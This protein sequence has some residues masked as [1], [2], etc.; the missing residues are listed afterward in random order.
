[1]IAAGIIYGTAFGLPLCDGDLAECTW[2]ARLSGAS[3][4]EALPAA[5]MVL[6]GFSLH[7]AAI[8]TLSRQA[9]WAGTRILPIIAPLVV[10][11]VQGNILADRGLYGVFICLPCAVVMLTITLWTGRNAWC[12]LAET[13]EAPCAACR[14]AATGILATGALFA[15]MAV[16]VAIGTIIESRTV[17]S[18]N[19]FAKLIDKESGEVWLTKVSRYDP[20][21]DSTTLKHLDALRLTEDVDIYR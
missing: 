20:P 17:Y 10:L 6:A 4:S 1:M 5:V 3:M 16:V 11:F 9:S 19:S 7:S 14:V 8:F 2:V 21:T 18:G 15:V 12:E 13:A